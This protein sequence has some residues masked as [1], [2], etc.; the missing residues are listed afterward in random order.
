L[1]LKGEVKTGDKCGKGNVEN[2]RGKKVKKEKNWN[3]AGGG[4]GFGEMTVEKTF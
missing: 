4:G 1:N 3:G 2:N